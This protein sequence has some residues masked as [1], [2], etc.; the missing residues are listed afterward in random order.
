MIEIGRLSLIPAHLL[1]R[2]ALRSTHP[3]TEYGFYYFKRVVYSQFH[4]RVDGLL[5]AAGDLL[6][7]GIKSR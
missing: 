1:Q 4:Q 5:A 3:S 7:R 6:K 2:S